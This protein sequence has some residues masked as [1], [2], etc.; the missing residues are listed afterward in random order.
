VRSGHLRVLHD[1]VRARRIAAE[2][3]LVLARRELTGL[4]QHQAE[5]RVHVRDRGF[6]DLELRAEVERHRGAG[7]DLHAVCGGRPR[8]A[9]DEH[10]L[11]AALVGDRG[12]LRLDAVA[13]ETDVAVRGAADDDALLTEARNH[14]KP[15]GV[16]NKRGTAMEPWSWSCQEPLANDPP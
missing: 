4:H 1:D 14:A 13:P 7:R 2:H 5:R 8:T 12:V 3:E 15:H 11:A 9:V 16:I 6:A 10:E